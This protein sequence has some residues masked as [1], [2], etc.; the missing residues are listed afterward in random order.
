MITPSRQPIDILDPAL[1]GEQ[2][3]HGPTPRWWPLIGH[4][5]QQKALTCGAR[6]VGLDA[7]RRS[8][9][10]DIAKRFLGKRPR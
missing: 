9:K 8:G 6:F 3:G 4:A 10:T 7:G 5:E 2:R 1:L